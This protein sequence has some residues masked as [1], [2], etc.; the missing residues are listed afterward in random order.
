MTPMRIGPPPGHQ[1]DGP[2]E[3]S[4]PSRIDDQP[5]SPSPTA[6]QAELL[7]FPRRAVRKP[8]AQHLVAVRISAFRAREAIGRTR[9]VM[10]SEG[11]LAWLVEALERLEAS[12]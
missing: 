6:L 12:S 5:N 3:A 11:D 7:P 10:I 4:F 9:P 1:E 8:R 2:V